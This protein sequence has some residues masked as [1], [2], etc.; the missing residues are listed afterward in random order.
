MST[1]PPLRLLCMVTMWTLLCL[2]L[3]GVAIGADTNPTACGPQ[4]RGHFREA[5]DQI[6]IR[7]KYQHFDFIKIY[8]YVT[9]QE[10][11]TILSTAQKLNMYTAGHIP[12]QVGLDGV[13]SEG[14]NEIA[15][16]EELIWEF[17]NLD[18]RRY[19]DSEDAWMGYVIQTMF[20]RLSPMFDLTPREQERTLETMVASVVDKLRDKP[21]PFCTTLVIDDLIVQKLFDPDG[22]LKRLESRYLPPSYLERFQKGLD[23]HQLQFKGGEEFAP[24]KY[25]LDKK[26]LVA[27]KTI[28]TPLLLSTD[29]GTGMMGAVPGFSVHDELGILVDNGFNP[30]DALAAGTVV[31]SK[32]VQRMNGKD[33]FGTIVP[34]KRADLL[35]LAQNP[36]D[37]VANARHIIGVMAAGRWYDQAAIAKMLDQ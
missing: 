1:G 32:I 26:L 24:F 8:A 33:E 18:R 3:S 10:Y 35:L 29:A 34:G 9:R 19:F 13:L 25:L 17:S 6:V 16:I 5:P 28:K 27:L 36:L 14:M 4:L 22:F 2:N 31:A 20:D 11:H 21:V 30:Y 7:Q 37:D 23:K 12:F 15:H